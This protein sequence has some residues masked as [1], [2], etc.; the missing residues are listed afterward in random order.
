MEFKIFSKS[1]YV[2]PIDSIVINRESRQRRA[3]VTE[4][5]KPSLTR[6][7]QMTP[8][9]VRRATRELV[10]GER[11]ITAMKELGWKDV[12]CRYVEEADPIELQIIELEE[13]LK[14]LDLDWKDQ[15]VAIATIHQLYCKVDPEWTAAETAQSL[16]ISQAAVSK[17]IRLWHEMQEGN[18]RLAGAAGSEQA[19]NLLARKDQRASA[20]ALEDLIRATPDSIKAPTASPLP[21][22]LAELNG[23][24]LEPKTLP[25]IIA[26]Q[27]D[28]IDASKTLSDIFHGSFLDWAP[29]YRA[30]IKFNLIHCDFPYGVNLF[31][32]E[33]GARGSDIT[34]EDTKDIYFQLLNCLCDNLDNFCSLSA[35]FVIW[36][37]SEFLEPTKAIF[38]NK[39]P[40]VQFVRD[41][42]IWGKSDNAGIIRDSRRTPR[43]TY[44]MALFGYRGDRHIVRSVADFYNAPTERGLHPSAKPEPVLR[45]FFQMLVD[46][47]TLL[48]DPTCGAGSALRAAD[49]LGASKVFGIELDPQHASISQTLLNNARRLRVASKITEKK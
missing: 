13:N 32:G 16:G 48:F 27:A 23:I 47:H 20:R 21:I 39:C 35:H 28:P 41:P 49:S 33:F 4:D 36:L 6:R 19:Y 40:S 11:R 7:G 43:H 42:L 22:G 12:L 31:K 9:L 5:L 45:H 26:K 46:E 3:F 1:T 10:A 34:Y 18:D 37:S 38:R 2:L 30:D 25:A 17:Q 15:V 14:R 29:D 8:I 44:E 24:I